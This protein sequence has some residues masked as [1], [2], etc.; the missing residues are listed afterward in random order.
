MCIFRKNDIN[1]GVEEYKNT[2]KAILIDVRSKREYIEGHIPESINIPL[3]DLVTEISSIVPD[4]DT[5]I[6]IY[7]YRGSRS[8]RASKRLKLLG[9]RNAKSIGGIS[10]YRGLTII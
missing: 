10:L 6:F 1:K 9:Y 8:N 3:E 2:D 4:R 5:Y 7:C